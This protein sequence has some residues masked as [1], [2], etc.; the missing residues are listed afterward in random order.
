M[1]RFQV[2]TLSAD[3]TPRRFAFIGTTKPSR[4]LCA[5]KKNSIA[6]MFD[7]RAY[8]PH[9]TANKDI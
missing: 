9:N 3:A 2:I 1:Q 8:L 5:V 6:E 4:P 7:R